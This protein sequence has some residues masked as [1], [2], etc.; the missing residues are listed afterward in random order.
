MCWEYRI[1]GFFFATRDIYRA[2][3][4]EILKYYNIVFQSIF[5]LVLPGPSPSSCCC[6]VH[7]WERRAGKK[8]RRSTLKT[9]SRK[10]AK[11]WQTCSR[12]PQS[13]FLFQATEEPIFIGASSSS[14]PCLP[15][16]AATAMPA[17]KTEKKRW[18]TA[19]FPVQHKAAKMHLFSVVVTAKVKRKKKPFATGTL[20]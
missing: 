13:L 19:R 7:F 2:I 8:R 15:L 6:T 14:S 18:K 11:R 17:W 4:K 12:P 10:E 5:L 1:S 20:S 16:T 3:I 9:S